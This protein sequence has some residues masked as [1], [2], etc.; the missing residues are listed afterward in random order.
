MSGGGG[1]QTDGGGSGVWLVQPQRGGGS[2]RVRIYPLFPTRRPPG[3]GAW[4]PA[5]WSA[6]PGTGSRPPQ[7]VWTVTPRRYAPQPSIGRTRF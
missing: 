7:A 5:Q 4:L 3:S 6:V 2:G 1:L